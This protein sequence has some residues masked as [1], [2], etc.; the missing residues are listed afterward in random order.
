MALTIFY[1]VFFYVIITQTVKSSIF[2][3]IC[4]NIKFTYV[5]NINKGKLSIK[6]IYNR[7]NTP[8]DIQESTYTYNKKKKDNHKI[9]F[10]NKNK[11][12]IKAVIDY[13][14]PINKKDLFSANVFYY[15]LN[16]TGHREYEEKN[17][18]LTSFFNSYTKGFS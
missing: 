12:T 4:I 2:Y 9:L 15:Y 11:N 1:F 16:H 8:H 5:Y 3:I 6:G 14:L 18:S 13:R 17:E 10:L 7:E